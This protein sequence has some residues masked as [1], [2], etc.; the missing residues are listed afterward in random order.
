MQDR[1]RAD[2]ALRLRIVER[3]SE[4]EA[5]AWDA[6]AH[7]RICVS[8][9]LLSTLEDTGCV[10]PETGWHPCHL[11]L[12][13]DDDLVAALPLYQK[14]H[15]Y[16]EYVFD[17]AWADAY[18]RHGLAYYPKLLSAVPF[19]PI[20]G[21]RLLGHDDAARQA[22]IRI[23]LE[24]AASSELSSLH[25]LFPDDR[26]THWMR[27]AG[28]SI[29][30]GVQFHWHNRGDRDFDAFLARLNH[31]KR[32]KIRQERRR[33][34]AHGLRCDWVDGH[35]ATEAEWRFFHRC[36]AATYAMHRSTPYLNEE[37]FPTLAA[38]TPD[39]VRLLLARRDGE[40]VAAAFFLRD[41]DALYGRYWGSSEPLPF[42]HFELCY[43]QAIEHCIAHGLE[44]FEGGAQGEH[45][46]A[47]GL[48]PTV[49]SSAHWLRDARFR[50]A[51]DH[52]LAREA[53]GI[54]FYLDEL[55]ERAPFRKPGAG[56]G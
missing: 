3:L 43:Y 13:R 17:W 52:Y 34:A 14:R 36:Y 37:F 51:V 28:L 47:R 21:V 23:A 49:T 4:L 39:R 12:W 30:H 48:E 45:K 8:H 44:R 27:E 35:Q 55:S 26:E 22:L 24:L 18:A 32:K 33:A 54:D 31:D 50:E 56:C 7:D 29:R 25:L 16:G 53:D 41:R 40:A 20:P 15:S 19:T 2:S 42:L 9:A 38:R 5:S 1:L 6:I 10:A 46:L 11:T